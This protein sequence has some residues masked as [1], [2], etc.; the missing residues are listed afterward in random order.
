MKNQDDGTLSLF[1]DFPPAPDPATLP[2]AA[3]AKKP[4]AK[5]KAAEP[6]A[7]VTNAHVSEPAQN[8]TTP[9]VTSE[10]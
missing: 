6:K 2:P 10:T 1:D 9:A 4:R 3:P 7:E 5:R 8:T